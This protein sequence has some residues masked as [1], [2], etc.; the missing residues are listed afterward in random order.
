MSTTRAHI[1]IA[2][3]H[4]EREQIKETAQWFGV[5]VS[6]LA[7]RLLL[8]PSGLYE[9]VPARPQRNGMTVD[10]WRKRRGEQAA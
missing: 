5:S 7:R 6:E 2:V 4:Q 3:T 10:E 9:D 8:E 1:N